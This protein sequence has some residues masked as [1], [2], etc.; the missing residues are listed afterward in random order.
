MRLIVICLALLVGCSKQEPSLLQPAGTSPMFTE[1]SLPYDLTFVSRDYSGGQ[2]TFTYQLDGATTPCSE[3][4]GPRLAYITD[5]SIEI[6]SCADALI[7]Y[8]PVGG[9][10]GE[11]PFGFVGIHWGVGYDDN[12]D[13]QYTI[14]FEGDVPAGVVTSVLSSH[15][16]VETHEITGPCGGF[17]IS[18]T[19]FTDTDQNNIQ[20][21]SELGIVGVTV[22]LTGGEGFSETTTDADGHYS[23]TK[24]GGSYT[25]SIEAATAAIDF[26]EN[27]EANFEPMGPVSRAVTV[28]PDSE[29]NSFGFEPD[30][31]SIIEK[32][33]AGDLT[34][35]GNSYKWWRRE[36]QWA[37][38]HNGN[39]V[40]TPA[41]L[42][43]FIH[44]IEDLALLYEYDFTPGHEL[45]EAYD[46]LN[47]HAHGED[48]ADGSEIMLD[49]KTG[50]DNGHD[51]FAFL[52]R[53][54]LTTEFNHVSGRGLSDLQLQ[55]LLVNWGEGL[56]ANHAPAAEVYTLP[57][58]ETPN[59]IESPLDGGGT[60]FRKLNGA[61]GGGGT[62]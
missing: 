13:F 34:T 59:I 11:T 19:V 17:Q 40:Y 18:G 1:T 47:N 29:G 56:L 43:A 6:P 60:I 46:I 57:G 62:N 24:T 9:D 4:V 44:N 21:G 22:K 12:E 36:L 23:F 8:G 58:D 30:V 15:G 20:S 41:Q 52:L 45:E 14:T 38:K 48:A 42:L 51:A 61:T 33:D 32:I 5:I 54:L 3:C 50:P 10:V 39:P 53:E 16:L 26:N 35:T 25:V 28:G 27:L 37:I 7:S 2:T 31:D 49:G 55:H